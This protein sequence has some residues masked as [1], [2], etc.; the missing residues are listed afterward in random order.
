MIQPMAL[1][2]LLLLIAA[3]TALVGVPVAL[4]AV[5]LGFRQWRVCAVAGLGTLLS[6]SPIVTSGLVM[7]W[8]T[9][10]HRLVWAP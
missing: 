8:I 2:A 3:L 9:T 10:Q 6:L 1:A 5:G 4:F 7:N